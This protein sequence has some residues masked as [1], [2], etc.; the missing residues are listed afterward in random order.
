VSRGP[1]PGGQVPHRRRA[2]LDLAWRTRRG[3]GTAPASMPGAAGWASG[4]SPG[5]S[6]TTT[7]PTCASR[8]SPTPSI[9]ARPASPRRAGRAA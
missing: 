4:C 6:P 2:D 1:G 3:A 9:R 5:R 8:G 7:A